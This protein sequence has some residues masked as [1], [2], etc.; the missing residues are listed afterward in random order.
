ML[1]DIQAT[2]IGVLM[3]RLLINLR[4][5]ASVRGIA[6]DGLTNGGLSV[7]SY[8]NPELWETRRTGDAEGRRKAGGMVFAARNVESMAQTTVVTDYGRV[9]VA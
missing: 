9:S 6:G 3:F 4:K 7:V 5:F 8:G 1:T 2:S